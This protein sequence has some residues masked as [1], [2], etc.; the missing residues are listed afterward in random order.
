[1]ADT[2]VR[3]AFR[4]GRVSGVNRPMTTQPV[5]Q[6]RH[7]G[8]DSDLQQAKSDLF[9]A[10][11]HTLMAISGGKAPRIQPRRRWA[12]PGVSKNACRRP[13]VRAPGEL[14]ESGVSIPHR[15]WLR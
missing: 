13:N 3:P 5:G 2:A 8:A 1:M 11:A 10:S 14:A 4:G 6:A 15:W 12:S 9:A 7:R